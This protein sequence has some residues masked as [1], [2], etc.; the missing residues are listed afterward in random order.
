MTIE[1]RVF[2]CWRCGSVQL[3]E[4]EMARQRLVTVSDSYRCTTCNSVLKDPLTG[5]RALKR[6][7]E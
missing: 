6:R 3:S 5:H 2:D 1:P 4:E 7:P